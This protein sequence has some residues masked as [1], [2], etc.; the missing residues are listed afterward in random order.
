M[1]S[2]AIYSQSGN[3]TALAGIV[4][5]LLSKLGINVDIA[6]LMTIAGGVAALYGVYRQW[7]AHKDLAVVTGVTQK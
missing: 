4:V 3:Y 7:V 1:Q 2:D 5:I 6:T